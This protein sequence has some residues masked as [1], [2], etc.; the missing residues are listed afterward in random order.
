MADIDPAPPGVVYGYVRQRRELA[1]YGIGQQLQVPRVFGV[2][3]GDGAAAADLQPVVGQQAVVKAQGAGVGEEGARTEVGGF[4]LGRAEH[5][6]DHRVGQDRH[7]PVLQQRIQ[8]LPGVSAG[9]HRHAPGPHHA[10]RRTQM[11]YAVPRLPR[12]HRAARVHPDAERTRL[13]HQPEREFERMDAHPLGLQHG[14]G[15]L[16][17]IAVVA[18]HF[19]RAEQARVIAEYFAPQLGLAAQ[20][21]Q[22]LRPVRQVEVA[23]VKRF[24]V[25]LR[26]ELPEVFEAGADFQVE[27][28]GGIQAPAFYPLRTAQAAAGVLPL[29]AAAAGA[30][31]RGLVGLQHQCLD[32]VFLRQVERGG[33]AAGAGADHH[34][35][36]IRVAPDGAV[37]RGWRTRAGHPVGGRIGAPGARVV[38][39][40]RVVAGVVAPLLR[41]KPGRTLHRLCAGHRQ[42]PRVW[43]PAD[44]AGFCGT[45]FSA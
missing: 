32:A 17:F 23:T 24:A 33:D 37:V 7:D 9:A 44:W 40:Q 43:R 29:A 12:L 30:A 15:R 5:P 10:A 22:L 20:V 16:A 26:A 19:L 39:H 13:G 36:G 42:R 18:P 8:F 28:L 2:G 38:G 25:D 21:F 45:H 41:R 11:V 27:P 31:P 14:A 6:R 1:R 3:P 35:L 34:H 4:Q